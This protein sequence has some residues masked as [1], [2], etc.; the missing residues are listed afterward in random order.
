[1]LLYALIIFSAW[2]NTENQLQV[3]L[4]ITLVV[5]YLLVCA[6]PDQVADRMEEELYFFIPVTGLHSHFPKE[7]NYFQFLILFSIFT[8]SGL[9]F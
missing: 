4:Y 9:F 1:M 8:F 5:Q 3:I 6:K 7:R 2:R